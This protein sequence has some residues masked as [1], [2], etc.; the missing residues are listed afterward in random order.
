MADIDAQLAALKR[1]TDERF[2]RIEER[3]SQIESHSRGP[4]G[5]RAGGNGLSGS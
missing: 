4:A 2:A 1:N 3:L 5:R